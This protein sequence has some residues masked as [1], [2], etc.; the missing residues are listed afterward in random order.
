MTDK[1]IKNA[2]K[3]VQKKLFVAIY[4]ASVAHYN[5]MVWQFY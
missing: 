2:N 4:N 1:L 5:F 3:S